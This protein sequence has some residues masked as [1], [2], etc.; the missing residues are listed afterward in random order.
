MGKSNNRIALT[1]TVIDTTT[2]MSEGNPGAITVMVNLM[3]ESPKVDP[4]DMFGPLGPLMSLDSY[5]I[6]GSRIWMLYKDVCNQSAVRTLAVL[7][8]MQLGLISDT[9]VDHAI[10]HRGEG[11]DVE[12]I[13]ARVKER[14]PAFNAV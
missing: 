8:G 12:E 11:L 14:L 7:R 6:Y 10:D 3:K 1:D 9:V 4:D 2:R 13:M 5:G